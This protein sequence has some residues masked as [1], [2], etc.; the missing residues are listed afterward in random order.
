MKLKIKTYA[1]I[2]ITMFSLISCL[3]NRP[4]AS[5]NY[6]FTKLFDFS[7]IAT[8]QHITSIYVVDDNTGFLLAKDKREIDWV[9]DGLTKAATVIFM[10]STDGGRTFERQILGEGE[11]K[12][13]SCSTDK[14]SFYMLWGR[15]TE[16]QAK[17]P[18][19]WAVLRS[20]DRGETWDE[21]YVFKDKRVAGVLFFDDNIGF[22]DVVEEPV[23][24]NVNTLYKTT[25]GGAS[26]EPTK[27]DVDEVSL[28][29][30]TPNRKLMGEL[31]GIQSYYWQMDIDSL[32]PERISIENPPEGV[33]S[34]DLQADPVTGLHHLRLTN[35]D[36]NT[37]YL[38]CLETKELLK[39]PSPCYEFNVYDGYIG[40][41]SEWPENSFV[42]QYHYSTDNGKTWRTETL[43]GRFAVN[44]VGMYGR[45]Q[46]WMMCMLANDIQY[47]LMIR[48]PTDEER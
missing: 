27:I 41:S 46:Y 42:K 13:L 8:D 31:Y 26:W 43:P 39:V 44:P 32:R 20:T 33:F 29:L 1:L 14:K 19:E 25:D 48:I 30:I 2:L 35:F 37:D 11:L 22:A 9:R 12:N 17:K 23:G 16:H 47:P 28:A 18:E 4:K 36:N 15:N 21:I 7:T 10:R 6:F 38:Y 24:Y 40:I 34:R 5:E 3:F 45:G